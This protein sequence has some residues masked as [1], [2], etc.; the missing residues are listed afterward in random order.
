MHEREQ[1]S[2]PNIS[3]VLPVQRGAI[4]HYPTITYC[5]A[6]IIQSSSDQGHLVYLTIIS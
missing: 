6:V 3:L 5:E 4:I 2:A 1:M